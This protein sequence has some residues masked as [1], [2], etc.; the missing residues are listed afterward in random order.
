M[1]TSLAL[2]IA[3]TGLGIFLL[4]NLIGGL[5]LISA[6][7]IAI[8]MIILQWLIAPSLIRFMYGLRPV[9]NTEHAWLDDIVTEL[10]IKSGLKK[11]LEVYI[12]PIEMANAFAF[13]NAFTGKKVAVTTGLL[14]ILTP[15][16]IK[17]VLGHELGHIKHRD[18]EVMMALSVLPALFYLIAR[19]AY[20]SG[21]F[22]SGG[23]EE[24]A[25]SSAVLLA[26][27]G[28]SMIMYY[29]LSLFMLWVS[30][31]R[32]HFADLHSAKIVENGSINLARAL[33]KLELTNTRIFRT[34]RT[35]YK[36]ML[37][38]K[39]LM[40]TDPERMPEIPYYSNIDEYVMS[41]ARKR[42]TL[43][44]KLAELFSTHPLTPKRIRL[45]LE[46]S[47]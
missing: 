30:R 33:A 11:K 24:R 42:I 18:V 40:I 17:A 23:S 46:T 12:A 27:A 21:L 7:I 25:S 20:Y 26:I 38:F 8:I 16:E 39:A 10:S 34:Q 41:L 14:R 29:I 45:L 35:A 47:S 22:G 28:F 13:G 44:E 36:N 43:G 1:I 32:E 9:K 19:W 3:L 4:A 37:A 6:F 15:E 31:T 2:T 5:S